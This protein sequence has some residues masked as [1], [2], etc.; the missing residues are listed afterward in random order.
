M[1][2]AGEKRNCYGDATWGGSK[3]MFGY[4]LDSIVGMLL[5]VI[6]YWRLY[7]SDLKEFEVVCG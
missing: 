1:G 2:Q 6:C 7:Y 3:E 4:V 5:E